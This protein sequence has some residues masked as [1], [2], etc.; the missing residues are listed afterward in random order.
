MLNKKEADITGNVTI[1]I[2]PDNTIINFYDL[3]GEVISWSSTLSSG[4]SGEDKVSTHATSKAA[5]TAVKKAVQTGM[6]EVDL[7]VKDESGADR[8]M[9]D[10]I[11]KSIIE[12]ILM[13]GMTINMVKEGRQIKI[14]PND[15]GH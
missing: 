5:E 8:E 14:S 13:G 4:F 15:Q 2:L 9:I 3:K 1:K 7:H 6:S 10:L 11:I 12:A